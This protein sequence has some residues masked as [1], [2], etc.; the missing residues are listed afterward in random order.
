MSDV[1]TGIMDAVESRTRIG[2]PPRALPT[3]HFE[4]NDDTIIC[5]TVH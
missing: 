2:G 1:N 3:T 5:E 4:R